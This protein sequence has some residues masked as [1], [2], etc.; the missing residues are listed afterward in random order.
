MSVLKSRKLDRESLRQMARIVLYLDYMLRLHSL[1]RG[2]IKD[3]EQLEEKIAVPSPVAQ[4]FLARFKAQS[5]S[6]IGET[7]Y[8]WWW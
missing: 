3:V 2:T 1:K 7:R 4:S 6:S 5:K 8:A